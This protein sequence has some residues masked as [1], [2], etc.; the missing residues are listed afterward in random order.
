MQKKSKAALNQAKGKNPIGIF[1]SGMGGLTVAHAVSRLLPNE[2]ILYFGDTAHTPWG[3]K[4][5][6]AIQQ[7]SLKI[8]ELLLSQ[9]CKAILI[10]CNT[11]SAIALDI[12]KEAVGDRA[13]LLNVIDPVIA[14]IE[15]NC[16]DQKIGLIGTKQTIRSNA[17][18][19]R[20][21][22]LSQQIS[23]SSLATPL[24][25]P[26]IEEGYAESSV[27]KSI[28]QDYL[29]HP[30]LKDISTLILGCTHYP[31]IKSTIL[32]HHGNKLAVIDSAELAAEALKEALS[33]HQLLNMEST[34]SNDKKLGQS[35][36]SKKVASPQHQFYISDHN[37]FF[38][39]LA[40]LFFTES[41]PVERYPI[42]D[43]P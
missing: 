30:N 36:K 37:E 17:Y 21:D 29:A 13:L 40:Q 27:A 20:L 28:I 23:L 1:D 12:V 42:W 15:A 41:V 43:N 34:G 39:N 22:A 14:H 4:S 18:K 16:T 5:T 31:L 32:E 6:E 38:A 7:Y 24:L 3:D 10:A 9:G 26:L 35:K 8:A 11:A 33:L 25:V 19:K 2:R